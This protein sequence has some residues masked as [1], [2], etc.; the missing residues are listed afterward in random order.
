MQNLRPNPR[1]AESK[2]HS[3]KIL[4]VI[5]VYCGIFFSLQLVMFLKQLC[6]LLLNLHQVI[7]SNRMYVTASKRHLSL[8]H[9]DI[10]RV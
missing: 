10:P 2:L 8:T 3:T 5:G 1:P 4:Q 9:Y 6:F 7:K